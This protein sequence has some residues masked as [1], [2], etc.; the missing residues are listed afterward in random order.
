MEE[1]LDE[2]ALTKLRH[3]Y[4]GGKLVVS[5][6]SKREVSLRQVLFRPSFRSWATMQRKGQRASWMR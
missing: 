5:A 2:V 1:E 6:E 4:G 3:T